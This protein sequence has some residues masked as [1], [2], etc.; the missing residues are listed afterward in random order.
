MSPSRLVALFLLTGTAFGQ[1]PADPLPEH[2]MARFGTV[3]FRT[4]SATAALAFS[5]DGKQLASW[6]DA[7]YKHGECTLWDAATGREVRSVRTRER[8]LLT[9]AWP[10][11]GP[12]LAVVKKGEA[13]A[14]GRTDT[15]DLIVWDFTADPP[16]SLPAPN[17]GGAMVVAAGGGPVATSYD[18][19]AVST[20]GKRLA[21]ATSVGGKPDTVVVFELKPAKSLTEL[22]RLAA[23][24]AP[25]VPC[26]A[27]AF[28]PA[29][30]TWSAC[31]REPRGKEAEAGTVV[32][33][34]A[35]GKIARTTDTP[36][37]SGPMERRLPGDVERRRGRRLASG[38]V[39]A[40]EPRHPDSAHPAAGPQRHGEFQA[41]G[42][43]ALAFSHPAGKALATYGSDGMVRLTGMAAGKVTREF[44]PHRSWPQ[45]VAF[46]ADGKRIASAR[47]GRG[48][49]GVGR[50]SAGKD[51]VPTG[52]HEGTVWRVSASADGKLVATEGGDETIRL[53]DPATGAER[54]RITV[55]GNVTACPTD[56]RRQAD[57]GCRRPVGQSEQ[58]LRAWDTATG[59]DA[60]PAG[61]PKACRPPASSSPRTARRS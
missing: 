36:A 21:V 60:T 46:S 3:R 13:F 61:F 39:F 41:A 16:A 27:L 17:R 2:A 47:A 19:A 22:K 43:F 33:W 54:R 5:P 48:D 6:G 31:A 55:G 51:A 49:S 57:G 30:S 10:A 29:A 20:D 56:P 38:D 11:G 53:W 42:V 9:P 18:V 1:P 40:I 59:A 7:M 15:A 58:A 25:P 12:G 32:V 45:A 14:G 35:A 44:G 52:G 23:F 8:A 4:G 50:E 34:D 26:K 28:T 24:D 37:R